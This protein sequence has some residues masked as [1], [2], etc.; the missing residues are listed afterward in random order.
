MKKIV[1]VLYLVFPSTV[2]YSQITDDDLN[3]IFT[4][5]YQSAENK[6]FEKA[7]NS[8]TRYLSLVDED[9]AIYAYY[10]R[11]NAYFLNS[12]FQNSH[13]DFTKALEIIYKT[14]DSNELKA[15]ALNYRG[16]SCESLGML[17]AASIDFFLSQLS[18]TTFYS[19]AFNSG[20]I[21]EQREIYD[22]ALEQYERA[23]YLNINYS[24]DID[25][26]CEVLYYHALLCRDLEN[27]N[28]AINSFQLFLKLDSA[29]TQVMNMLGN[30]Y[31]TINKFDNAIEVYNKALEIKPDFKDAVFN[32][33]VALLKINRY[34]QAIVEF[35]KAI[36]LD[37]TNP[38]YF[39]SLGVAQFFHSQ[40]NKEELNYCKT[41]KTACELGECTIYNEF[42]ATKNENDTDLKQY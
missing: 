41:L 25:G 3:S 36:K 39:Q 37:S 42:C 35:N 30:T 34:K 17:D 14:G 1:L 22:L 40:M 15:Y 16:L 38:D 12:E 19:A 20:R 4:E 10:N 7:I 6:S 23:I 2:M 26:L 28:D 32:K 8:Y 18:D 11:G 29:N 24:S 13:D 5:A 21:A 33:G 31:A 9:S 27:Y